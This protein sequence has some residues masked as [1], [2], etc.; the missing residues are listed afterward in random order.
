MA[1]PT[2]NLDRTQTVT[3]ANP[4]PPT[5]VAALYQGTPP[6]PQGLSAV[7]TSTPDAVNLWLLADPLNGAVAAHWPPVP[8]PPTELAGKAEAD[9]TEVTTA[10]GN[11]TGHSVLGNYTEAPNQTHP[12]AVDP[13]FG[14]E[15]VTLG[16][17]SAATGWTLSGGASIAGGRLVMD[18]SGNGQASRAPAAAITAG[19]YLYEFDIITSAWPVFVGVGGTPLNVP[20]SNGPGHFVG[21][22]TSDASAQTVTL[23]SL[24]NACVLDNFSVKKRL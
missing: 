7:Q 17:F 11:S 22:I 18:G 12:S 6:T 5:N 15:L 13:V 2:T 19:V 24:S 20:G 23:T 10:I 14:S 16:D 3:L 21:L 4:T 8:P 1:A 9:G